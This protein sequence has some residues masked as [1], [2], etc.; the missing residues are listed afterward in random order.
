[1][2]RRGPIIREQG[3]IPTGIFRISDFRPKAVQLVSRN[4]AVITD[5]LQT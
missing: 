4:Q 5:R 3:L 2:Q 1:M